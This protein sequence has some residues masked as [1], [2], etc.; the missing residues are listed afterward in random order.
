MISNI[1]VIIIDD[2]MISLRYLLFH[3]FRGWTAPY[4]P[5]KIVGT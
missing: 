3:H 2:S 4:V 1:I 5:T